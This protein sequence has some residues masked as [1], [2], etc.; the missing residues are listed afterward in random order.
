MTKKKKLGRPP[1]ASGR[2]ER[3]NVTLPPDVETWLRAYGNGNLS[4]AIAELAREK[5]ARK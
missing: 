2:R 1:L 5:M 4:G 3:I